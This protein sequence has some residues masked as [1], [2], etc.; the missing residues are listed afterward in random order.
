M[1][2]FKVTLHKLSYFPCKGT[3]L[4]SP[5]TD[6]YVSLLLQHSQSTRLSDIEN[7]ISHRAVAEATWQQS[8][9]DK[10]NVSPSGFRLKVTVRRLDG[11]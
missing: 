5:H 7:G 2:F 4:F 9:T 6:R 10:L 1:Q 11:P 8:S 3:P